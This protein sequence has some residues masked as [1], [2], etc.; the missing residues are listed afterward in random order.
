MAL[1]RP[2]PILTSFLLCAAGI[3]AG[4][5]KPRYYSAEVRE[6]SPKRDLIV[7]HYRS[8]ALGF[9]PVPQ[10]IWLIS[11][12]DPAVRRLLFSHERSASVL[13]SDDEEWLV[14]ND[15]C[16]S[17]QSRLLLFHRKGPLD[18][19]QVADLTEAAWHY[20]DEQQHA[21]APNGFD[22]AYVEALRWADSDPPTLLLVLDGHMDSRNYT[23]EW[24]C[25]YEV[26]AKAFNM[27]F[28]LH[29]RHTTKL[30]E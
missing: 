1:S 30:E 27:D 6:V 21:K 17:D 4:D 29:N 20:F 13:F 14:I 22:H 16:L 7:E 15:H 2:L 8:N 10:Q 9:S 11:T 5:G 24:Y 12:S 19:E 25:L 28:A 3:R 23:S 26:R 18:Y